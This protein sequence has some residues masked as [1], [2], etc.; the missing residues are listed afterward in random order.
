MRAAPITPRPSPRDLNT[1]ATSQIKLP[2]GSTSLRGIAV[3]PDGTLAY[4]AHL[5]GR[6][7]LPT[8][9][10]N[11]GWMLNNVVSIIDLTTNQVYASLPLDAVKNGAANRWG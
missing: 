11:S 3:S 8:S 10:L 4:V 1:F 6:T 7:Y 2:P 9:Q 5:L